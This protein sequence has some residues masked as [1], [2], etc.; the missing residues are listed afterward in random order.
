MIPG[1]SSQGLVRPLPLELDESPFSLAQLIGGVADTFAL[2]AN[3]KG[4]TL[5]VEPLPDG[6]P[7]LVG[8][9]ARL[10]RIL[11]NLVGNAIKFTK[12][13][14]MTVSVEALGRSAGS[15]RLRVAVRDTGIGIAPEPAGKL[16]EPFVQADRTT[17]KPSGGT[18]LG[19]A[20]GKRLVELM[21]GEIG[22]ETEQG[23]GSAFWFVVAFRTASPLAG[24][25]ETPAA[26]RGDEKHLCGMR[27]LVVDD[28]ETNREAAIRLLC[29]EGAVCEAADTGRAA[30]DRFRAGPDDFDCMLM[31]VRM[32]E[33]DGLE[34]TRA[35]RLDLGLVDLPV[36]A[37]T[38]S[39]MAGQRQMA[40]DAG[41][42]GFVGK[43]F[44]LRELVAALS[45]WMRF[46]APERAA[47]AR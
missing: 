11:V 25:K 3:G 7:A 36:I 24:P 21:G 39:T 34:A 16:F 47:G 26:A 40:L 4:L 9:A 8:D 32:P 18:G 28:T 19:L 31:D 38:A 42:N 22:V 17:Y 37:L 10:R 33:M 45:P 5:R 20:I 15:L 12:E 1:G 6:L 35:I 30:I 29:L 13:G 23:R 14:G 27:L 44:R 41:M 43:P 46:E 2:S